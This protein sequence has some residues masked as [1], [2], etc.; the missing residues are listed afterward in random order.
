VAVVPTRGMSA[1]LSVPTQW[2]PPLAV[3]AAAIAVSRSPWPPPVAASRSLGAS[4]PPPP[5]RHRVLQCC[6]H[7][8][9]PRYPLAYAATSLS[10]C[11]A[12]T[13]GWPMPLVRHIRMAPGWAPRAHGRGDPWSPV[14]SCW[15]PLVHCYGDPWSPAANCWAPR[16]HVEG[17]PWSPA[18]SWPVQLPLRSKCTGGSA[19]V[20]TCG[21][22][23]CYRR[24]MMVRRA[25]AVLL[26]LVR[27]MVD[28]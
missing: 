3:A 19:R 4:R 12:A 7:G 15:S 13:A 5:E 27:K 24:E 9:Y 25:L 2:A 11:V 14:A 6:G 17:D 23:L 26:M 10:P 16:G 22:S 8:G 20:T 18:A 28:P 1:L 21:A